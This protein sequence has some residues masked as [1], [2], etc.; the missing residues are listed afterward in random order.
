MRISDWSSDVC[1]SDLVAATVPL[2]EVL[3]QGCT[4]AVRSVVD[5]Q[6]FVAILRQTLASQTLH[7]FL[8]QKSGVPGA[9]RNADARTWQRVAHRSS[10]QQLPVARQQLRSS[11]PGRLVRR[12]PRSEERR[13]GNTWSRT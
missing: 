8:D 2:A 1:S 4:L 13:E 6:Y 12:P 9:E 10:A 11:R 5:E 3:D 7:C